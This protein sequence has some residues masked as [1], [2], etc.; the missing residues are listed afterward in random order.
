MQNKAD[1]NMDKIWEFFENFNEFVYAVDITTHKV[2]YMN[3]KA[4]EIY[5]ITDMEEIA[6]TRCYQLLR[7]CPSPC[8]DCENG[9]FQQ[10]VFR[11]TELF[12][13]VME[14]N[15][16]IKDTLVEKDGRLCR[17][18]IAIDVTEEHKMIKQL[19][20]MCF[21]DPL[22]G[23]G[24]R[25]A[26]DDYMKRI[27]SEKSV[28]V[29]YCD[30][31]GLK[32]VNDNQGHVAGDR[33]I[34]SASECLR[35]VF[36]DIGI[37]R[38]GGDEMLVIAAG[39]KEEE[40]TAKIRYLRSAMK[41]YKVVIAVGEVWTPRATADIDQFLVESESRMYEDKAQYYKDKALQRRV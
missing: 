2:V 5:G 35:E 27:F 1:D 9:R 38:I 29:V 8:E 20:N 4:R 17:L 26:M 3:R 40:F 14:R 25:F 13:P 36:G 6:Q 24:N 15:L 10:G 33:L 23:L 31:T 22:T 41:R 21:T 30:I 34:L 39:I 32:T 18:E 16:R 11:E 12:H 7:H 28:G 37:F 19:Q